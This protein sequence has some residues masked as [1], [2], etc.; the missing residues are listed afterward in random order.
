M[1]TIDKQQYKSGSLLELAKKKLAEKEIKNARATALTTNPYTGTS[2]FTSQPETPRVSPLRDLGQQVNQRGLFGLAAEGGRVVGEKAGDI[3]GRIV[4]GTLGAILGATVK[5]DQS[6]SRLQN[7]IEESKKLSKATGEFGKGVVGE[8]ISLF[9]RAIQTTIDVARMTPRVISGKED[10]FIDCVA[11]KFIQQVPGV[12]RQQARNYLLTGNYD[13]DIKNID[14]NE[15]TKAW[16]ASLLPIGMDMWIAGSLATSA[17]NGHYAKNPT[18]GYRAT[19]SMKIDFDKGVA[20]LIKK[21]QPTRTEIFKPKEGFTGS[22]EVT[23]AEPTLGRKLASPITEINK[24]L[25]RSQYT[26]PEQARL[27]ASNPVTP[28]EPQA[29]VNNGVALRAPFQQLEAGKTAYAPPVQSPQVGFQM[30]DPKVQKTAQTLKTKLEKALIE[31]QALVGKGASPKIIEEVKKLQTVIDKLNTKL[32]GAEQKSIIASGPIKQPQAEVISPEPIK[33]PAPSVKLSTPTVTSVKPI[34]KSVTKKIKKVETED[35]KI[36]K[37]YHGSDLGKLKIDKNG[38]INLGT[39]PDEIKQFG[40]SVTIDTSEMKIMKFPNKE[41]LFKASENKGYYSRKGYD[42]L[43]SGNQAIA[44]NPIKFAKKVELPVRDIRKMT[45]GGEET[46]YREATTPKKPVGRQSQGAITVE[47]AYQAARE[48]KQRLKEAKTYK[49]YLLEQE[50]KREKFKPKETPEQIRERLAIEK[51]EYK[52]K[53]EALTLIEE[54]TPSKP[55]IEKRAYQQQL[56]KWKKEGKDNDFF[57]K[58]Y[59]EEF[60]AGNDLKSDM[61]FDFMQDQPGFSKLNQIIDM[62]TLKPFERALNKGV[63]EGL[64]FLYKAVGGP[65]ILESLKH[66]LQK[67]ELINYLGRKVIYRYGQPDWYKGLSDAAEKGIIK[68]DN[69]SEEMYN[70]LSKGLTEN[71]KVSLQEAIINGGYH[72]DPKIGDRAL[73]ARRILDDYGEQFYRVGAISREVFEKNKGQYLMRAYYNH[74]LR[75]PLSEWISNSGAE[76]ASLARAKKRGIEKTVTINQAEKLISEGWEDRDIIKSRPGYQK[77]WRD[78][79]KEERRVM[80]EVLEA[81]EYLVAKSI[82]QVGY[83]VAILNKFMKV[84]KHNDAVKDIPYKNF[85]QI[86]DSKQYGALRGKYVD[87]F[88]YED[89]KG[90]ITAKDAAK[91]WTNQMLSE[92]KKFKVID[93]PATHFRNMYFNFLLS[94]IAGLSPHRMDI[95]GSSLIDITHKQGDFIEARNEGLFGS[96]WTG[97]ELGNMLEG[98]NKR[99]LN[100]SKL[101]MKS[102]GI[103]KVDFKS[104]LGSSVLDIPSKLKQLYNNVQDNL[105]SLYEAEE[106]WNKLSLYKYAKYDLGMPIEDAVK[107]AKKWGLNYSAV[108]PFMAGLSQKWYG[109]PFI[110]F[111]LL[112]APRLIEATFTRPA[113]IA[114]WILISYFLEEQARKKL[115]LTKEGLKDLKK[116]LFPGWMQEGLYILYPEKDKYGQYQFMDLSYI[117]PFVQD[118]KAFNPLNFIFQNPAVQYASAIISNKDP[119]LDTEIQDK[120]VDPGMKGWLNAYGKYFYKQIVPP[121]FPGGYNWTKVMNAIH[122]NKDISIEDKVT[123]IQTVSSSIADS[124]FGLKLRTVDPADQQQMRLVEIKKEYDTLI[125]EIKKVGK[126]WAPYTRYTNDEKRERIMYL[127]ERIREILERGAEISEINI[128]AFEQ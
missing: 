14:K 24:P 22:Y 20:E 77:V 76:K 36:S 4:G 100:P 72:P 44:I 19:E 87:P 84:A 75:K 124:I 126:G 115:G 12:D 104:R 2:S 48:I 91:K 5:P 57:M 94:D 99:K 69:V 88:I 92:W 58:K 102:E 74:E 33:T 90:I 38:N 49:D 111:Q 21:D 97:N 54:I 65:Q 59:Q 108:S 61:L 128:E 81:P 45:V 16:Y 6:K 55:A 103:Y 89:V 62:L 86:P 116:G 7:A 41:E 42:I 73:M 27:Q 8:G 52:K 10:V 67:S 37:L 26:A 80:G 79:T 120:V 82:K 95:Y 122:D 40:E 71:E 70:Y 121:I 46:K 13:G 112:A 3:L 96:T 30:I 78:F 119:F 28:P 63:E 60:D 85:E 109:I 18:K 113:T 11:D 106:Q 125:A 50:K 123:Q 34:V 35:I 15:V 53:Q 39:S 51:A 98:I 29:P 25:I 56:E 64:K 101:S 83:D 110:R 43:M 107:F 1:F 114:K 47:Q 68:A 118:V 93:N 31:K 66:T 117:V 32:Q 17:Y 127:T 105:G 9:P 23:R